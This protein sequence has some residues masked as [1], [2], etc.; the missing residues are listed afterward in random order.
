MQ[1]AAIILIGMLAALYAP[2][3]EPAPPD[4]QAFVPRSARLTQQLGVDFENDGVHE[5]VLVYN[6]LDT[7]IK[8]LKY[9]E[10]IGWS[11]LFEET[12]SQM[13]ASNDEFSAHLLRSSMGKEG[14]MVVHHHSGAGTVT[15]WK[16]WADLKG[17][18]SLLD[19][20]P[21]RLRALKRHGYQDWG[22]NTVTTDGDMI[23][24]SQSGY[25]TKTA[26]CCQ[27][28]PLLH[29][30]FRFTGTKIELVSVTKAA[31]LP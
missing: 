10:G 24:E 2:A 16:V 27:D 29:M 18:I 17:K 14:V 3:A 12:P 6:T 15:G 1:S 9:R 22:Y 30:K 8:I 20:E 5:V 31:D 26:R 7:V 19:P 13:M 21:L 23:V 11:V 25:S 4:L 28:L